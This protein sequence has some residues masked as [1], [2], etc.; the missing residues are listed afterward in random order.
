MNLLLE[1]GD[2]SRRPADVR[3]I[4]K[5]GTLLKMCQPSAESRRAPAERSFMKGKKRRGPILFFEQDVREETPRIRGED[6]KLWQ[7]DV[8]LPEIVGWI[9]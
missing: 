6:P 3:Q 1:K 2:L 7:N 9:A 8:F 5:K 4:S